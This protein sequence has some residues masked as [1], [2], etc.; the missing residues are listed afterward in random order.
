MRRARAS[1]ALVLTLLAL[2]TVTTAILAFV[3]GHAGVLSTDAA[4]AALSTAEPGAGAVQAQTRIGDDPA[5]QDAT[6]RAKLT[7]GF[8]PA[9]VTIHTTRVSEPRRATVD[10]SELPERLTLWAG[11]HLRPGL[12]TVTGG[13][14]PTGATEAALQAGAAA[15]TGL[16]V[17]DVVTVDGHDLEVT[18]LWEPAAPSSPVWFGD[19]LVLD[20]VDAT[21]SGPLVVDG[22]VIT[23]GDPFIRWSVVPDT[24]RITPEALSVLAAGAERAK[25][26][27]AEADITGRGIV[28]DGDLA[29]TA[30]RAARDWEVGRAFGI[31]PVSVLLLVAAVG[32]VQV[33]GLLA[34][35]RER[36][37]ALLAARGAARTQ[38]LVTG[39]LEAAVVAVL[40]AGLGTALALGAIWLTSRTTA[41]FGIVLLGGAGSLLL[42]LAAL[43]AMTIRSTASPIGRTRADRVRTVAG[44]AALVV[45]FAA[46]AVTTWQLR[47][48]ARLELVPALAPALLLA[49][50]AVLGLAVLGPLSRLAM[51]L[52]RLGGTPLWLAGAQLARGLLVHAVPVTLTILATG[53]ATVASLYAGTAA[54][55]HRDQTMLTV[56]APLRA[57][58]SSLDADTQTL[59][60]PELAAVEGVTE[61]V[62]VWLDEAA[63]VGDLPVTVLAAPLDKLD[64]VAALPEGLALPSLPT[65]K[66]ETEPMTLPAGTATLTVDLAGRLVLDPWQQ[67]YLD[68]LMEF[69]RAAMAGLPDSEILA[70]MWTEDHLRTLSAPLTISSELTLRDLVTGLSRTIPGPRLEVPP[71]QVSWAD[72]FVDITFSPSEA[73]A[74]RD[75][76]LPERGSFVLEAVQVEGPA[77]DYAGNRTLELDVTFLADG[78]PVT[79]AQDWTADNA[80]PHR[81][82]GPYRDAVAAVDPAWEL[83]EEAVPGPDGGEVTISTPTSNR[84]PLPAAIIDTSS[85]TWHLVASPVPA[86]L[87]VGPA[88]AFVS[89]DPLGVMSGRGLTTP[90]PVPVAITQ[91]LAE[92]S[93]LG[94]GSTI[95]LASFGRRVPA[96]VTAVTPALPGLT[97][98]FGVL[99]ESGTVAAQLATTSTPLR[100][101]SQLWATVDGD[102]G[103]VRAAAARL[104]GVTA[105]RSPDEAPDR[106]AT[107][108]RSL[109]IAAGC[110]L[111]LSLTGLASASATQLT[112]RRSEVA[113][114][115]ALGMTPRAQGRSRILETG[116][117]LV[118]G[119]LAGIGAGIAVAWLVVE[120]LVSA[121]Q[122]AGQRFRSPLT[123][124]L[125]PWALLLAVGAAAVGLIL[126]LVGRA[127]QRQA[128]DA[129]YREEVR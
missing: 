38:L 57:T 96:V 75:I 104:P 114:L 86:L 110:A 9:P 128:L 48:S 26:L 69:H 103:E 97:N 88:V 3:V 72:G 46:A 2:V 62:P 17:G 39:L 25:A 11:E 63:R 56:G 52:A 59:A 31:V 117:T 27:V 81:F 37:H 55:T 115:R 82:A 95:D 111:L 77:N 120:P 91:A 109:W 116:G 121:A 15:A 42:A 35:T 21:S 93:T 54:A 99:A 16:T 40:G 129:E 73:T 43:G 53:T 107:A 51:A 41:Q 98:P 76:A 87:T 49:A 127:V 29:S 92:T 28:V 32:L 71:P 112:A 22:S 19:P 6:A 90:E 125:L 64:D 60:L 113:V 78:E 119:T 79:G 50:A 23:G 10:G 61:A 18:A 36:E 84:P 34:G 7:Q 68:R 122:D 45:V 123:P 67:L 65:P 106:T 33:S 20:G 1:L 4:R 85:A 44:A 24:N 8:S 100:W 66:R 70:Q 58:L 105:V 13:T 89:E 74:S 118:I 126:W 5:A 14:W 101:P 124:D 30:E 94:I 102:P 12:I 83:E 47:G 108:A 80:V